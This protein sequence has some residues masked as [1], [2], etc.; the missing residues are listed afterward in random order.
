MLSVSLFLCL[1][2][3]I[4]F[5]SLWNKW[6]SCSHRVWVSAAGCTSFTHRPL[7][8][9]RWPFQSLSLSKC[10]WCIQTLLASANANANPHI[11]WAHTFV[12]WV[13]IMF[14]ITAIL[15]SCA[16][17]AGCVSERILLLFKPNIMHIYRLDQE[18]VN[19]YSVVSSR[20]ICSIIVVYRVIELWCR[21]VQHNHR[22]LLL[23]Q[24]M[25][26]INDLESGKIVT[27]STIY[28]LS[29]FLSR[30][31]TYYHKS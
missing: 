10:Q 26:M 3:S 25:I 13:T 18:S 27:F 23:F 15:H 12:T 29:H 8:Q 5:P 6:R 2:L 11:A 31:M 1:Y 24:H 9:A 21:W 22:F 20:C 16:I 28:S 19:A 4:Y 7:S 17:S 30:Q 14:I